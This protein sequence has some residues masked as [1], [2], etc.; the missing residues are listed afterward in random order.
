MG[1]Y[2]LL[3]LFVAYRFADGWT[4]ELRWNN[5]TDKA[6]E[7]AKHYNT[8]GSNVFVWVRWTAAP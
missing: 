3:N 7:L 1:G 8:P 5:V 6:Y 2:A 4:A